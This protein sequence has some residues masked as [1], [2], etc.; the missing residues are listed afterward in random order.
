MGSRGVARAAFAAW[1]SV[2]AWGVPA[3]AE[4]GVQCGKAAWYELGGT[5]ASGEDADPSG[6]T[7]AHRTLPFGT[8][9]RV[10]NLTNG[11]S[12]VVRVNDRGPYGGGRV[13]DLSR[14]AA[15]KLGYIR[16]GVA[17]VKVTVLDGDSAGLP[18]SCT[19]RTASI[20]PG[21]ADPSA[22]AGAAAKAKAAAA[23]AAVEAEAVPLPPRRPDVAVLGYFPPTLV[24]RFNDAFRPD[25]SPFT[26][27][28]DRNR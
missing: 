19:E 7:A 17:N 10:E 15:E 5:T 12:V 2:A 23:L 13:I 14:A 11:R 9:V 28:L 8:R 26:I 20:A 27:L 22:K 1:L 6:M 4:A 18:S 24:L 3:V 25:D 16:A 21:K